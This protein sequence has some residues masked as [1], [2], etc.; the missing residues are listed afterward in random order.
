MAQVLDKGLIE[1]TDFMGGDSSVVKRARV[2]NLPTRVEKPRSPEQD[3]R[4]IKYL[5]TRRHGSPFEGSVFEFYVKCP[6]FVRSEWH[7]HRMA[8]YNEMSGRYVQYEPEFYIPEQAR[9]QAPTNKQGSIIPDDEF[10]REWQAE[11]QGQEYP[12]A[13]ILKSP[14]DSY[15]WNTI[16]T[17]SM[18]AYSLYLDL[19]ANGVAKEMARMVLPPNLYTAFYM[20]VNARSLMNFLSLRNADN[21]QWEIREYAIAMEAIFQEKMP[22]TY[23]AWFNNSRTSP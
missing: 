3:Q 16:Y 8:S 15:V 5:V 1:L 12:V 14:Y 17:A 10:K 23:S 11:R 21:A 22:Q 13:G 7:R 20:T 9:I 6:L 2:S 19:L 18:T 4:L